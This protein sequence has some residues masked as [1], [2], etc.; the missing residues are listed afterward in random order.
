MIKWSPRAVALGAKPL[1][2]VDRLSGRYREAAQAGSTIPNVIAL[3][4]DSVVDLWRLKQ[5]FPR[6]LPWIDADYGSAAF[7]PLVDGGKY[8]VTISPLGGLVARP[9][10]DVTA[11]KLKA[12]DW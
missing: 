7:L 8:A 4:A 12:N 6:A 2:R 9:A 3:D 1:F 10:D 5:D 11:E